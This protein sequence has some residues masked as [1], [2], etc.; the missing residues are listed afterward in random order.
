MAYEK[1]STQVRLLRGW[2]R[3]LC[4]SFN[5]QISEA[6][7]HTIAGASEAGHE[8]AGENKGCGLI[9][10]VLKKRLEQ[11]REGAGPSSQLLALFAERGEAKR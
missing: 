6:T 1:R 5:Y 3:D 9:L 4:L 7:S 8:G 11:A 10:F 2:Q